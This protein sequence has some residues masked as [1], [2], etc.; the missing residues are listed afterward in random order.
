MACNRPVDAYYSNTLNAT[1]KRSLVF[2][3][4]FAYRGNDPTIP[5]SLKVP[6][7]K[8]LGCKSDA[9]LMWSLRAYHESTLHKQNSFITLT[10]DNQHLPADGKIDKR[11]LQLFFKKLRK[12]IDGQ[13]SK[14]P[15]KIRYIACGE[16]GGKTRRPHYHAII[17]GKDWLENKVDID[18]K[19]YTNSS[20]VEVWGKGM[21]SIAPV[22]MGS[23]CYVCGYVTKKIDD[24]DTFNLMSRR[25]G[26][27][28]NWLDTYAGDIARTGVV[29]VEGRSYQVPKRYLEWSEEL[30]DVKD[31]RKKFAAEKQR[32]SDS[33]VNFK[34]QIA[35]EKNLA[36]KR[37]AK[38][39][40]EKI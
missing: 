10:Y 9:C 20:L 35:R 30:A 17:F 18:Q 3:Q 37:A 12:E 1:G 40:S 33:L 11:E 25:P 24:P 19:M 2:N 22:T 34:L 6:C 8:C 14:L 7:G 32:K 27:G 23:I 5:P 39:L 15:T 21:V 16:Y 38:K 26:I 4:K 13:C 29:T 28:H 36:A 31:A